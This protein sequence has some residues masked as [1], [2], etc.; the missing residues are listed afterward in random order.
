[1]WWTDLPPADDAGKLMSSILPDVVNDALFALEEGMA[2]L[3]TL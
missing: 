2:A 1:M 3:C